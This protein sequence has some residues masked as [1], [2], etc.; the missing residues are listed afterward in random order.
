MEM[1]EFY[2]ED[3]IRVSLFNLDH[4]AV[5][6]HFH[7]TVSD[8]IYC[9]EGSINIELP[10]IKKLYNVKSGN[11]FQIPPNIKHRFAN[12]EEKGRL[13]RYILLQI[14]TFDIEFMK[15][16][17]ELQSMLKK[18]ILESNA[19][20]KIYIENRKE[21]ILAL[22]NK[23]SCNKP[24]VLTTKENQDVITALRIFAKDGVETPYPISEE[25]L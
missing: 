24:E 4:E 6:F 23:F 22:A 7:K 20:T 13:S 17:T 14:G 10:E 2:Y 1:K 21:N 19:S 5:S 15:N 3:G 18:T 16:T 9:S 8:M 11:V 12:G 25:K